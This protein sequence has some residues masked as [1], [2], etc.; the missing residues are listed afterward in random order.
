MERESTGSAIDGT[1][2]SVA[3]ERATPGDMAF[4]HALMA[5]SGAARLLAEEGG[6]D[7]LPGL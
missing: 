4:L 1:A 5:K 3:G 2:Q 6:D 7:R